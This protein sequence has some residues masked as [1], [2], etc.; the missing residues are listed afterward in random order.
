MNDI[1]IIYIAFGLLAFLC[2]GALLGEVA[3]R[4]AKMFG[5]EY[6]QK[7]NVDFMDRLNKG[8]VITANNMFE[9]KND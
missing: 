1:S 8:E 9:I 2:L 6:E 5:F 7:S 4:L 3:V